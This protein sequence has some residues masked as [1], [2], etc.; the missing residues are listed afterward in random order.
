M[1]LDIFMYELISFNLIYLDEEKNKGYFPIPISYT[2]LYQIRCEARLGTY[3]EENKP[4]VE[5]NIQILDG[6]YKIKSK[7]IFKRQLTDRFVE[8]FNNFKLDEINE[9]VSALLTYEFLN[10]NSSFII[11]IEIFEIKL[12]F[13]ES[14]N[15]TKE[16]KDEILEINIKY[17][18]GEYNDALSRI[19]NL[20]EL[21]AREL[22][23]KNKISWKNFGSAI[24]AL[25]KIEKPKSKINYKYLG[26]LLSSLYY[27]RNQTHH[28]E[29]EILIN[30]SV[31]EYAI[32]NISLIL[33]HIQN[34]NIKF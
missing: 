21:I 24:F 17:L 2:S 3:K 27:I 30:K 11:L 1:F 29:P 34:K 9:G 25:L 12:K 26:H 20:A 4:H 31:A 16:K 13:I 6:S 15:T 8:S 28:P 5:G 18:L 14:L 33:E 22:L 7:I 19:G 32:K 23:R 10:I